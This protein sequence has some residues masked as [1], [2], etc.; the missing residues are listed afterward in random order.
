MRARR[1]AARAGRGRGCR[2]CSGTLPSPRRASRDV[3]SISGLMSGHQRHVFAV[4]VGS[5]VFVMRPVRGG[6]PGDKNPQR[7]MHLRRRETD[8]LVSF[9]VSN[10]SS[11]S[12]WI[13]GVRIS[14]G[15]TARAFARSTGCPMR[16]IFRIDIREL[17]ARQSA[18]E[19]ATEEHGRHQT[20]TDRR[21]LPCPFTSRRFDSVRPAGARS[22]RGS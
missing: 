1:S 11:M 20:E 7:F 12:C 9:I 6:K 15:C 21:H 4:L 14:E 13:V 5:V 10:M 8:S 18:T 17:Y 19:E 22:K 2:E 3:T 16:A